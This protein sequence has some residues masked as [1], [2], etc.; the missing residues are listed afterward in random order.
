MGV[1]TDGVDVQLLVLNAVRR[2]MHGYVGLVIQIDN[3]MNAGEKYK[4]TQDG[5]KRNVWLQD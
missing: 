3:T 2:E 4:V 5:M 1:W